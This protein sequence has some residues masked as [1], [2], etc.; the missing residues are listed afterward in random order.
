MN[1]YQHLFFDLDG[2][3]T[4]P[5]LGI[6]S[7]I[8]Y[9]LESVNQPVSDLSSLRHLI[10]PPLKDTF[11]KAYQFDEDKAEFCIAKYRERFASKGMYE[12]EL[13]PN[14]IELL[15]YIKQNNY[16]I[17]LATS[18]PEYFAKKIVQHFKIDHYFDFIG[19]AAMDDSRPTKAHVIQ[20]VIEHVNIVPDKTCLMIGDRKHDIIGGRSKG[21]ST[22][23]VL[24]GFGNEAELQQA[25][26][27]HI[28]NDLKSL[29]T[30]L[31]TQAKRT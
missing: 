4:D 20:H 23:G 28:L 19:G 5:A 9:A 29:K 6:T 22:L 25:G 1:R 3:L 21:M 8:A 31:N 27:D 15:D 16:K 12:N 17:Y 30:F 11:T 10:G 26:A 24:C 13:L 2:T 18:K 14:A 7:C